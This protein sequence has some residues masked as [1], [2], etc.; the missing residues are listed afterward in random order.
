MNPPELMAIDRLLWVSSVG[1]AIN[2]FGMY[3]TGG[4]HHHGHGHG[5]DHGHGHSH[6]HNH[7]AV[8]EKKVCSVCRR[9]KGLMR[10]RL[11]TDMMTITNPPC[12]EKVPK[13]YV[14][15]TRYHG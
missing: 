14:S 1:L 3:A 4:H 11:I 13:G 10:S 9:Q 2:L 15:Y 5:H 6:G 7:I 8:N 12:I